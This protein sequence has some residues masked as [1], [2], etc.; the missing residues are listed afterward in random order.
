MA[1]VDVFV[2]QEAAHIEYEADAEEF[3]QNEAD[4]GRNMRSGVDD[5]NSPCQ[6]EPTRHQCA[7]DYVVQSCRQRRAAVVLQTVPSYA[8]VRDRC[9]RRV[10][11]LTTDSSGLEG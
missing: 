4:G 5:L 3:F 7:D 8:V 9:G 1:R 10:Q 11:L 6:T 2:G